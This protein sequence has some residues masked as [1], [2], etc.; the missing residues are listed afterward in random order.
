MISVVPTSF[1]FIDGALAVCPLIPFT[2]C[3]CVCVS[4]C[5]PVPV[6][7][8]DGSP[9]R[10]NDSLP[11]PGRVAQAAT[12][13]VVKQVCDQPH[14][15][16]PDFFA[17]L[18][19]FMWPESSEALACVSK[20]AETIGSSLYVRIVDKGVGHM[21]GFCKSWAW[22]QLEAFLAEGYTATPDTP[23]AIS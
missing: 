23:D 19:R 7:Y 3:V 20:Q 13:K 2:K 12:I 1:V 22:D 11:L 4:V 15:P 17:A 18:P 21:W 6:S 5:V 16:Y 8:P 9:C 10:P 14:A